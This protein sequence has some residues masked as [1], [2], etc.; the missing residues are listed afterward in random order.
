MKQKKTSIFMHLV[1]GLRDAKQ[2]SWD[3][4]LGNF[5]KMESSQVNEILKPLLLGWSYLG[6]KT[7][8][9]AKSIKLKEKRGFELLSLLHTALALQ[10][11]EKISVIDKLLDEA[12]GSVEETPSRLAL[13]AANYYQKTGRTDTAINLIDKIKSKD[14]N[15]EILKGDDAP[16]KALVFPR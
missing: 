12:I 7:K 9:S 5:T 4:A 16:L 1:I 10:D 8:S 2:G 6:K 14:F 15:L 3:K 13:T 11:Q